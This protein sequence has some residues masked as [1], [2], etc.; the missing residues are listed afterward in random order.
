[1]EGFNNE[2][3]SSAIAYA[4][5]I[6]N[7]LKERIVGGIY[8]RYDRNSDILFVKISRRDTTRVY[9]TGKSG[10]MEKMYNGVT[11]QELADEFFNGYK[12]YIM[13]EMFK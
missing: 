7:I 6:R 9:E 1:M 2:Q 5:N 10:I 11:S 8:V 12:S 3:I 13:K 4:G